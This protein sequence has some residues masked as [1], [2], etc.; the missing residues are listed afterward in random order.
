MNAAPRVPSVRSR[1]GGAAVLGLVTLLF[2]ALSMASLYTH[3]HQVIEQRSLTQQLRAVQAH[4]AA[5]AGLQWLLARLN[6]GPVDARCQ[7]TASPGAPRLRERWLQHEADSG[8]W[9]PRLSAAGEAPWAECVHVPDEPSWRCTCPAEG[10]PLAG[11]T[12]GEAASPGFRVRLVEV[13]DRPGLVGAE[14]VGCTRA[15]E[16]CLGFSGSPHGHEGRATLSALLVFAPALATAPAAAL[17]ARGSVILDEAHPQLIDAHPESTGWTVHAG[18]GVQVRPGSLQGRAGTPPELTVAQDDAAL[19]GLSPN[20]LFRSTFGLPHRVFQALPTTRTLRC[21]A[22]GCSARV[23]REAAASHPGHALWL[24]GDLLVDDS[25]DLGSPTQPLLLIVDGQVRLDAPA[26]LFGLLYVRAAGWLAE[27]SAA[28]QGA[29]VAEGSVVGRLDA[30]VT[31]DA[32]VLQA[33]RRSH[34]T[35]ALVPGSWSDLP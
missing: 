11:E 33:L 28:L 15:G 24:Q 25:A 14:V 30:R 12:P 27:G 8:R 19:A 9:I 21:E 34:G 29:V 16:A 20:A 26:R 23:V 13:S 18:G 4:E 31:R 6:S 5:E 7:A 17:T 22:T 32:A 35:F 3:R 1:S 10:T 2:F